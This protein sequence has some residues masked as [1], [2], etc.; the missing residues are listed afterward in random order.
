MLFK[1]YLQEHAHDSNL[2][3]KCTS[4]NCESQFSNVSSFRKHFIRKHS[5]QVSKQFINTKDINLLEDPSIVLEGI[6]F[7]EVEKTFLKPNNFDNNDTSSSLANN[8]LELKVNHNVSDTVL[9]KIMCIFEVK[10]DSAVVKLKINA[11]NENLEMET[12]NKVVEPI[13]SLQ[14]EIK[15]LDT[16]H[17]QLN[18][19]KNE[20]YV[21]PVK[22]TIANKESFIYIPIL[23]SL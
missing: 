10:I 12:L 9:K 17:K 16:N 14:S 7:P 19:M 4:L 18:Q 20:N 6:E 22:I 21:A 23:K 3:I 13:F 8:L 11:D 5:S 15:S 2:I 1:H